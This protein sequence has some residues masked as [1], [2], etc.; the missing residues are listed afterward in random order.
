MSVRALRHIILGLFI[1]SK[2]AAGF[3]QRELTHSRM[4]LSAG[5]HWRQS[6]FGK[7]NGDGMSTYCSPLFTS[8]DIAPRQHRWG[9][10]VTSYMVQATAVVALVVYAMTA[11]T[12]VPSQVQHIDLV[13]PEL[14]LAPRA[15][16]LAAVK[17]RPVPR[18]EPAHVTAA[19][20]KISAP[21][22]QVQLP[23]RVHRTPEV[24][25]IAQPQITIATPKFDSK[26]LNAL[27]GP[28]AA[29][30]II[31]TNTFGGSSA[32]PTLQH[33]APSKVQ[34]GGF[35][36]PNGVPV[37][38]NGSNRPN[39]AAT[40]SFDLPSG[41][42]YGNGTGGKS[43]ARGTVASAGFGNGVAV[44][45][46]GGRGGNAGQGRIQSTGFAPAPVV[47]QKSEEAR[48]NVKSNPA[49][50]VPVSIQSK[51]NPV[52]TPE[53]R[54]RKV[55]GEVLLNVIFTADGKIRVLNVVRG[56]GY[57]LD[58]SA[59]RAVQG[60]KFSPAMRDGHPVDSNATLHVIFQLS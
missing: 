48:R 39:I 57:G 47:P 15:K 14:D 12:I 52:Y 11:P 37:N 21:V 17:L 7:E 38:A 19:P 18:I 27:P 23:Q 25:E 28:K 46:G 54:A 58:E 9:S 40:G 29:S 32:T 3:A 59:R 42:G 41:G 5:L 31:A 20:P 55:E 45:G 50:S 22:L 6:G 56:L 36:D 53:A 26:V 24:A 33:V 44:Q 34:T 35:G 49:V 43:G 10:F 16:P 30:R 51:P 13:A 2:E 60:L 8:I 4:G 1:D